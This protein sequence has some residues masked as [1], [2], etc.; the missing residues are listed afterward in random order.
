MSNKNKA[1]NDFFVNW[2]KIKSM[3]YKSVI[4][5]LVKRNSEKK[6]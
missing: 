5:L 6:N 3:S 2:N 1:P 4:E